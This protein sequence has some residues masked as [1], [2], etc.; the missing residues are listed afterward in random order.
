MKRSV[1]VALAALML[2]TLVGGAAVAAD[3]PRTLTWEDLVPPAPPLEDPL[4][5]LNEDQRV[6]IDMLA[7][8]RLRMARGEIREGDPLYEDN[9]ELT[10]KLK[11]D[12][13]DVEFKLQRYEMVMQEIER[14][15]ELVNSTLNGGLVR[16]PGYALPLETVGTSVKSFLLVPF[17]GACIHVPPPPVNQMVLVHL[18]Q[19][20][21]AK[22]LYEPVWVTGILKTERTRS[23]LNYVDGSGALDTGYTLA[24]TKVESYKE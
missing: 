22:A 24:G 9:L 10:E 23:T 12:G 17:L 5:G 1:H 19:S 2:L 21:K 13:L 11:A 4:I 20:Y 3:E 7:A 8:I 15:N 18:K 16:I 6:E 14:R